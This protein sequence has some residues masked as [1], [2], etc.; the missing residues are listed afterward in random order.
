M[1][2]QHSGIKKNDKHKI[3]ELILNRLG[4][5]NEVSI[6]INRSLSNPNFDSLVISFEKMMV[7]HAV[8][9][10][11][12]YNKEKTKIQYRQ[13][14]DIYVKQLQDYVAILQ[15]VGLNAAYTTKDYV[16]SGSG[17]NPHINVEGTLEKILNKLDPKSQDE[18]SITLADLKKENAD[19]KKQLS[20]FQNEYK[21]SSI[22]PSPRRR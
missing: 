13:Y 18:M 10:A 9:D 14:E 22:P 3:R 7:F 1:F 12:G 5:N 16:G 21:T 19:L 8:S 4:L 17:W 6:Y 11:N 20:Q 2:G 15:A